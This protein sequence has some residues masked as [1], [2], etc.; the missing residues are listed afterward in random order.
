VQARRQKDVK[1]QISSEL[2]F[3]ID[4][5]WQDLNQKRI[6]LESRVDIQRQVNSEA[7]GYEQTSDSIKKLIDRSIPSLNLYSLYQQQNA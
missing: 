5:V 4:E 7:T 1:K 2:Q 6:L 3:G